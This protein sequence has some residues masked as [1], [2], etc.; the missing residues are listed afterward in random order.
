MGN[1]WPKLAG[2]IDNR[3]TYKNL[4]LN[5]MFTYAW[6]Q[7]MTVGAQNQWS[8]PFGTTKINPPTHMLQRWQNPG[9]ETPVS[10]VTTENIVWGG[11]SKHLHR[12]DYLRLKDLTVGYRV[13][14]GG[15]AF[16]DGVNVYAKC[17]NLWTLTKAPD[18]FWD[19]E[20]APVVQSRG[21]GNTGALGTFRAAPQARWYLLGISLDF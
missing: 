3:F 20:Y 7:E 19:P 5:I 15:N 18:F 17:T 21:A 8:R 12:T 11:N 1:P 13:N 2:G 10:K 14:T 16:I 4:Y 6:G 9:D